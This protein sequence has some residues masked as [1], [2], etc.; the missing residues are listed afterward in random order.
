MPIEFIGMIGTRQIS[1]L[2]EPRVGITGGS[3]DAAYVRKFAKA[4][5][6]GVFDRV[7]VGYGSML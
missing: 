1:E 7:L 3:I 6:N 2:D 5:E 4:H